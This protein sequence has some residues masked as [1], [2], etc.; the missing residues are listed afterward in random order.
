MLFSLIFESTTMFYFVG[1]I[2]AVLTFN[3]RRAEFSGY[4][5]KC[6]HTHACDAYGLTDE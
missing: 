6:G 3:V 2:L 1:V 4:F 5:T